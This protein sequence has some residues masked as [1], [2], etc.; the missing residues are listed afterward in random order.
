MVF[1]VT[2]PSGSGKSTILRHVLKDMRQVAFSVS[3]T[4]RPP[5]PSEQD[6][7]EYHFVSEAEFRRL[8]NR[9]AFAEWAVV[10]GHHY[11]T[12]KAE[13]R[14]LGRT[15]DV[16]LDIDVQGARQ[17]RERVPG[18]VF[19]FVMPPSLATLRKRLRERDEDD[20]ATIG[21]RL[22][23]AKSEIREAGRFDYIVV[24]DR[25]DRAVLE[26]EAIV[27][28]ARCR[29]EIRRRLVRTVLAGRT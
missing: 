8:I 9:E 20:A 19:I 7:R 15:S 21:T 26:L 12:S 27:L 18:A 23:N 10:H 3:H 1:V 4:T 28:S 22:R 25:L 5:R 6:G 16:I 14:R 29:A 17:I 24:N 13:I 11:G 2:G